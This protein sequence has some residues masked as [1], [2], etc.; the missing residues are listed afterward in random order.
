MGMICSGEPADDLIKCREDVISI[1][2][3]ATHPNLEM[4]VVLGLGHVMDSAISQEQ[5]GFVGPEAY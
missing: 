2:L 4:Q 1:S 3:K 5:Q